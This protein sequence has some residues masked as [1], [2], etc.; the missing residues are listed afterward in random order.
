MKYNLNIYLA[1]LLIVISA[2]GGRNKE[3]SD[4]NDSVLGNSENSVVQLKVQT[5]EDR[6]S[7]IKHWYSCWKENKSKDCR[8]IN[9]PIEV[10]A[11]KT[12][13]E[14]CSLGDSIVVVSYSSL[15]EDGGTGFYY[16][17]FK[18]TLF[19]FEEQTSSSGYEDSV[20]L[21]Y[22]ESGDLIFG[23]E[24]QKNEWENTHFTDREIKRIEDFSKRHFSH[25]ESASSI[26]QKQ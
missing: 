15:F 4:S 16:Y 21:F 22:S 7:Q 24:S 8:K 6:V 23:T 14:R 20:K 11:E 19:C 18:G 26:L 5:K 13:C 17:Y 12:T 9:V 25:L 10:N 3:S 2:C 1:A